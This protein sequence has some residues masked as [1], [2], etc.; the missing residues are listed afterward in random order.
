MPLGEVWC[1]LTLR[2]FPREGF[3]E[4]RPGSFVGVRVEPSTGAD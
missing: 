1:A 2:R 4:L 3:N